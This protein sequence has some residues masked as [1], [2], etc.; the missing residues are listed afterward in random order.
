MVRAEQD[1]L[2]PRRR[3]EG[4]DPA[5]N[6]RS[7]P[8]A[9]RSPTAS[10]CWPPA[11][12]RLPPIPGLKDV[13]FHV[14]RTLD[15][16]TRLNAG[17]PQTKQAVVLGAGLVGM[18]AAE[19]LAKAGAQVTVVEMAAR[20]RRLFRCR[21]PPPSSKPPSPT[22]RIHPH[23]QQKSVAARRPRLPPR[24]TITGKRRHAG[25]RPAAGGD[26]RAPNTDFLAGSGVA[27]E[28]AA[29]WSTTHA[30]SVPDGIGPPATCAQAKSFYSE[31]K[32]INGILPDAAEQGGSPAWPW[33]ATRHQALPRRRAAQYLHLLRPAG[34]FRRQPGGGR[35]GGAFRGSRAKRYLKIVMQEGRLTGIFG[36]NVNSSMP[37]VMRRS[38]CAAST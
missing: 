9:R 27:V 30:T 1:R 33:P 31:A 36:I 19:N 34:G 24:V 11:R 23:R 15:D 35:R 7:S 29:S 32:V 37:G 38:S 6:A 14:L 25:R 8:A 26:R 2:H 18:H 4:V 12:R 20:H 17:L 22:R 5:R 16:A 13:S 21:R 3:R 28:R 10:C